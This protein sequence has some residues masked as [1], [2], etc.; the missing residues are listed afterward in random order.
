[1]EKHLVFFDVDGTTVFNNTEVRDA[2]V[3]ALLRLQKAGHEIFL[4]TGRSRSVLPRVLLDKV[5]FDGFVCGSVYVEYHGKV[6]HRKCMD[7]ESVRGF[8]RYAKE[9]GVSL[10]LEG[11]KQS[12]GINGGCFH[13]CIEI[14]EALEDCLGFEKP[15]FGCPLLADWLCGAAE[16]EEGRGMTV[17]LIG[18]CTDICVVSNAMLI[19]AA[20]PEAEV[21]V[22]GSLCAGV[23]PEAHTAAL[24]TMRSCQIEIK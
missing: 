3:E 22:D 7:D 18:V 23:T 12:Y 6:L 8:C 19:K 9:N 17:E 11:E 13:P 16:D 20:L 2:D 14:T 21:I 5:K 15:T 4:N 10:L 1:M 24:M